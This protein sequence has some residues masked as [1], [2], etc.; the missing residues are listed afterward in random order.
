MFI[1]FGVFDHRGVYSDTV[2]MY[3]DENQA[4]GMEIHRDLQM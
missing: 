1:Y 2:Y 3:F 4:R